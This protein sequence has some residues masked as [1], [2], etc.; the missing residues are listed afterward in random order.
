MQLCHE[1]TKTSSWSINSVHP[2]NDT[3]VSPLQPM[4]SNCYAHPL[5]ITKS[6][7][8]R[9]CKQPHN[10][11]HRAQLFDDVL[12]IMCKEKKQCGVKA[13]R[14]SIAS[15]VWADCKVMQ[16]LYSIS[17]TLRCDRVTCLI[18]TAT[19]PTKCSQ[20]LHL[21]HGVWEP[22]WD[23]VSDVS[24][25]ICLSASLHTEFKRN[26]LLMIGIIKKNIIKVAENNLLFAGCLQNSC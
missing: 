18:I 1:S 8:T 3:L 10:V 25:F 14:R 23:Q 6:L 21:C 12:V 11:C 2:W 19:V 5:T 7:F 13:E 20:E 9:R 17:K 26:Y 24:V 16:V 15:S 4:W 22:H